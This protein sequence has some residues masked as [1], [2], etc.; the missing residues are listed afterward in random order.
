MLNPLPSRSPRLQ[1]RL[2]VEIARCVQ[3]VQA[4]VQRQRQAADVLEQGRLFAMLNI[5]DRRLARIDVCTH[6]LLR[7]TI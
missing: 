4:E 1:A 6:L 7:N 3:H 5:A 2:Q